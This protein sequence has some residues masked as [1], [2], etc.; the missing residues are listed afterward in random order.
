M[1]MYLQCGH[2][3][4][5]HCKELIT[6]WKGGTAILSPRDND[7]PQLKKMASSIRAIPGGHVLLDPQFYVPHSE[8]EKLCSHDYWP[9]DYDS[10]TFT[11]GP[12]LAKLM[13][14]LLK[15]IRPYSR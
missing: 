2:G 9:D 4:M 1:E 7:E 14:N 10:F 3:M 12:G 13:Q 8:R 5:N 6:R 11:Q 15:Y